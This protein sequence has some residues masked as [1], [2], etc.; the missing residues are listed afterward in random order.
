M[1]EFF[2]NKI[3]KFWI[4]EHE[5]FKGILNK[6]KGRYEFTILDKIFDSSK[7]YILINGTIENYKLSFI[8]INKP[9]ESK[10][11]FNEFR[12]TYYVKQLFI[13]RFFNNFDDIKF[14][15]VRIKINNIANVIN[16]SPLNDFLTCDEENS[17]VIVSFEEVEPYCVNL[18]DF[19]LKLCFEKYSTMKHMGTGEFIDSE[20]AISVVLDYDNYQSLSRIR[21]DVVI[22]QNLFTFITGKSEII[23]L[24]SIEEKNKIHIISPMVS[25]K[26]FV[27]NWMPTAIQ[28]NERN[29]TE[30]FK[31]W[32]DN[33][34][35][36]NS[37]YD[38]FC[39]I[40]E[41][42]LNPSTLFLSYAQILESYH[43][44]RYVGEYI[45]KKDFKKI[46][47]EIYKCTKN[48]DEIKNLP[49]DY[50]KGQLKMK[51]K[52]SITHSFEYTLNDRLIEIFNKL[53]VY[54]F[55]EDILDQ[56][57]NLDDVDKLE[58]FAE[59]IRD[60]RN[61]YTHY[62]NRKDAVVEGFELIKLNDLLKLTIHLILLME[63]GF[64]TEEINRITEEDPNFSFI[65]VY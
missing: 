8:L 57:T 44:K 63:L 36:L 12:K 35:N 32:F 37:I 11:T 47:K 46:V 53:T 7:D 4:S 19:M 6:N 52:S 31:K 24:T 17:R 49:D 22:L 9:V 20:L 27:N 50:N 62:G 14:N 60:N 40:D 25:N 43:R 3:G 28:I 18:D 61:Y 59:I 64:S 30:I 39:S 2:V 58:S 65:E 41:I 34:N 21:K 23:D 33:Y 48:S 56:N 5:I 15:N 51:I 55:F 13:G 42:H 26:T 54:D 1:N 29:Y 16:F 38:L 10:L 45:S